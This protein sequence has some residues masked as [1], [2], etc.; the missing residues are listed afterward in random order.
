M[1]LWA[2]R[3]KWIHS[4]TLQNQTIS[5]FCYIQ[6]GWPGSRLSCKAG[7]KH[8]WD[9]Q[10]AET[11]SLQFCFSPVMSCHKAEVVLA[12]ARNR[13]APGRWNSWKLSISYHL[14]LARVQSLLGGLGM[15]S[16]NVFGTIVVSTVLLSFLSLAS[17]FILIWRNLTKR[18]NHVGLKLANHFKCIRQHNIWIHLI[19][20]LW[21]NEAYRTRLADGIERLQDP[22]N[23][24][25]LPMS[26]SVVGHIR[27]NFEYIRI[28]R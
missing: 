5:Q 18:N 1:Q 25:Q 15:G 8:Y 2:N 4:Q 21:I 10:L 24:S 19:Y 9:V 28:I 20:E 7:E 17:T 22:S 12:L 14:R 27:I 23:T 11:L 6:P 26:Q 13:Q 3:P 16:S